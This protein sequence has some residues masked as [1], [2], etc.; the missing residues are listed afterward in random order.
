MVGATVLVKNPNNQWNPAI[1]LEDHGGNFKLV[2]FW[3]SG[4]RMGMCDTIVIQDAQPMPLD[5]DD[6][7]AARP[8]TYWR[9]I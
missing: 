7:E 5:V 4:Q 6:E 2:A 1:V 3:D 9:A 8:W